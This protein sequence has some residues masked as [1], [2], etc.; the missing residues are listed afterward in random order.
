M[1]SFHTLVTLGLMSSAIVGTLAV[2]PLAISRDGS[3][4]RG[5]LLWVIGWLLAVVLMVYIPQFF[6]SGILQL[7]SL[8]A[9]LSGL[10]DG[11][12]DAAFRK[13]VQAGEGQHLDNDEQTFP[14]YGRVWPEDPEKRNTHQYV[15][16]QYWFFYAFND[17]RTRYNGIDDHEGDWEHITLILS[18]NKR[19]GPLHRT[20]LLYSQHILP[21]AFL[22]R[23]WDDPA[24]VR[25]RH[26]DGWH[27]VAYVA[28]GSHA[29]YY[30]RGKHGLEELLRFSKPASRLYAALLRS[31][32]KARTK[33]NT[34][35]ADVSIKIARTYNMG[36]LGEYLMIWPQGGLPQ[37]ERMDIEEFVDYAGVSHTD[38]L[39]QETGTSIG[40][41]QVAG[42][43]CVLIGDD[44]PEW[45]RYNGNWGKYVAYGGESAPRGPRFASKLT[46]R[47]EWSDPINAAGL[48]PIILREE[49][50]P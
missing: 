18:R 48:L 44:S 47:D 21:G 2:G 5:V 36:F 33:A 27:P 14:Y 39:S 50:T 11:T 9:L 43:E 28:A 49:E 41:G 40:P 38:P 13:S 19:G 29:H 12:A 3:S 20:Y 6:R 45:M 32:E 31:R 4:I 24:V 34:E 15:V 17:W 10:N 23:A 30:S 42:W 16:L 22:R 25:V 35:R 37:I 46:N 8:F 26:G 1:R 7:S